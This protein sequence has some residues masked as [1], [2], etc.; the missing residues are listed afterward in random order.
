MGSLFLFVQGTLNTFGALGH[1]DKT[2][3]SRPRLVE[4]LKGIKI[5]KVFCGTHKTYAIDVKGQVFAWG[6]GYGPFPNAIDFFTKKRILIVDIAIATDRWVGEF[7]LEWKDHE[8]DLPRGVTLYLSD[9]GLVYWTTEESPMPR[10]VEAVKQHFVVKVACGDRAA[11]FLTDQGEVFSWYPCIIIFLFIANTQQSS[12]RPSSGRW[13]NGE[14]GNIPMSRDGA[15]SHK[16]NTGMPLF[17]DRVWLPLN[18][19]IATIDGCGPGGCAIDRNGRLFVWGECV[20]PPSSLWLLRSDYS[21]LA[22]C[23]LLTPLLMSMST[24]CSRSR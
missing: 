9:I 2:A 11:Y 10:L 21:L 17:V 4:K 19:P 23:L 18:L 8:S 20:A 12:V 6:K 1:G 24:W 14:T 13:I 7:K 15:Q 16:D 3:R 22:A 5:E